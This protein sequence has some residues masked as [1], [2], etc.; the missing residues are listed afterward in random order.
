MEEMIFYAEK[1]D[2]KNR[3]KK[4]IVIKI[5]TFLFFFSIILFSNKNN[6]FEIIEIL[7]TLFFIAIIVITTLQESIDYIYEIRINNQNIK[8]FG[9]KFNQKWEETIDLQKVNIKIIERRSKTGSIV[10]YLIE[11][12]TKEKKYRINRLFNWN[13]FTLYE[14]FKTFKTVKKEKIIIDE[15][16][17]IDGIEKRAKEKYEWQNT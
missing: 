11:L 17:L 2:F 15:K 10:G 4:D 7:F 8:I 13:N 9:E 3:I 12:K 5:I 6:R 14:I 16:S 1:M